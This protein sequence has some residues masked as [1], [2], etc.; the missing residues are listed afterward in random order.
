MTT[1]V[2]LK[3]T[4]R[5]EDDCSN[6]VVVIIHAYGRWRGNDE[7]KRGGADDAETMMTETTAMMKTTRRR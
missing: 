1:L 3:S 6:N 7:G 2:H 4:L 5:Y